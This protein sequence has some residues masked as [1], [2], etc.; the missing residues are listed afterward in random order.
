MELVPDLMEREFGAWDG[1][2]HEDLS[3]SDP[4]YLDFIRSFGRK[5]PPG[6]EPFEVFYERLSRVMAAIEELALSRPQSFPLALVFHGGPIL[7]LTDQFLPGED[8]LHRYYAKG[9]GGVHFE[10]GTGPFRVEEARELFTDDLP[11]ELTPFYL[12]VDL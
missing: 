7:H 11:V 6:G 4:R 1:R 9:A 5:T 2:T 12:D 10:I 3:A 8:P